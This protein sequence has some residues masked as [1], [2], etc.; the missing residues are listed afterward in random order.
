MGPTWNINQFILQLAV[1]LILILQLLESVRSNKSIVVFFVSLR[2]LAA[3]DLEGWNSPLLS[4][5]LAVAPS[6]FTTLY[7]TPQIFPSQNCSLNDHAK[8]L[9]FN[10][11]V[12]ICIQCV[13]SSLRLLSKIFLKTK[14]NPWISQK[15]RV[16]KGLPN[17]KG[18]DISFMRT[19]YIYRR[20]VI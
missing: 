2:R 11:A 12:A 16:G 17:K 20:I 6:T 3:R 9:S 1:E 18:L 14:E 10:I 7:I 5:L 15:A 8:L 4:H 19:N 13:K